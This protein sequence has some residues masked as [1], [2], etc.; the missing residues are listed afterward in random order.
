M[1]VCLVFFKEYLFGT[2]TIFLIWLLSFIAV[3]TIGKLHNGKQN[4]IMALRALA[5]GTLLSDALLHLI[6][7]AFGLHSHGHDDE[8]DDHDDE[9]ETRSELDPVWK[10]TVSVGS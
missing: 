4:I 5:V 7:S 9:E 2:L 8:H 1:F 3:F 6:P 10:M